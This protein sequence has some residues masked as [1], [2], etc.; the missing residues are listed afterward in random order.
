MS[1]LKACLVLCSSIGLLPALGIYFVTTSTFALFY[2][3]FQ[4]FGINYRSSSPFQDDK[5][6]KESVKKESV[7]TSD[8]YDDLCITAWMFFFM[9]FAPLTTGTFVISWMLMGF[10]NVSVCDLHCQRK[11]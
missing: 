6:K 10:S 2:S 4:V 1:A 8:A 5:S 3:I 7:S 11:N 9:T